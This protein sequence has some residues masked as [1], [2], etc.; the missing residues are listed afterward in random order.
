MTS[1]LQKQGR[2]APDH[3]RHED[4]RAGA[5]TGENR[6]F[7]IGGSLDPQAVCHY[8]LHI[9]NFIYR[10]LF[11]RSF[12]GFSVTTFCRT[13]SILGPMYDWVP[14]AIAI[15]AFAAISGSLR[16]MVAP[17]KGEKKLNG[18]TAL[19]QSV[20]QIVMFVLLIFVLLAVLGSMTNR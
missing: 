8:T 5:R 9:A 3:G 4:F 14:L 18:K 11:K 6:S 13:C 16:R 12:H 17:L 7:C 10:A 2:I 20:V 15:V 19:I 1:S